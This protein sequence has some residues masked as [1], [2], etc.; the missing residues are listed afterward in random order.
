VAG[1]NR[2]SQNTVGFSGARIASHAIFVALRI[3]A[4]YPRRDPK[5]RELMD[6][7]GMSR[8]T[9]YRWLS[10]IRD[11]RGALATDQEA[12]RVA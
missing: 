11:A 1:V 6:D 7:F 12:R 4:K 5:P 3:I 2:Y 10:A 9:A 8:A